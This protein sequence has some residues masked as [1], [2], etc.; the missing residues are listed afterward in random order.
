M[1]IYIFL[2]QVE[3]NSLMRQEMAG[4]SSEL[5]QGHAMKW[6]VELLAY[7]LEE[8]SVRQAYKGRL[9]G[10]VLNG[11]LNLRRLVLQRTRLVE[12]TQDLL[13]QLLGDMTTGTEAE[14]KQF[15]S[16]CVQTLRQCL[17]DDLVTPVFVV[18]R[19]CSIIHPEEKDDVEF[20]MSL[21]KDPQQ[22]D[23][24]QG[25]CIFITMQLIIKCPL[26]LYVYMI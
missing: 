6:M 20:L 2:L 24:L 23:F 11:Y 16:V 18:E 12:E 10:H 7:F 25:N 17:S 21:D 13:L 9:V 22:E 19:L 5:S 26:I 14:I 8:S 15:M 1:L 4:R 3:I